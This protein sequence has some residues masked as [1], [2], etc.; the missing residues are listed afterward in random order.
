MTFQT[1]D[2]V[3]ITN[4]D[5]SV[6]QVV[7]IQN[8]WEAG[9]ARVWPAAHGSTFWNTE[10]MKHARTHRP[11]KVGDV[12]KVERIASGNRVGSFDTRD[13]AQAAINE[14]MRADMTGRADP[15]HY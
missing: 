12:W 6:S 5:G 2:L 4:H 11:V 14:S 7:E 9:Q 1:G 13:E 8:I 15:M 10:T 3:T